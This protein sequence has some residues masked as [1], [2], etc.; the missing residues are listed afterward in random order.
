MQDSRRNTGLRKAWSHVGTLCGSLQNS[1]DVLELSFTTLGLEIRSKLLE[2][3][4]QTV[5]TL[6]TALELLDC[7]QM[8]ISFI[9]KRGVLEFV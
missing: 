1:N 8:S 5:V 7:P 6:Q 9:Q 3:N 2:S 4:C